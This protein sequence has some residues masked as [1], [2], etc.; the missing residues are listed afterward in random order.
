M[1]LLCGVTLQQMAVVAVVQ[2]SEKLS[3]MLTFLPAIP[4]SFGSVGCIRL[5]MCLRFLRSL[6]RDCWWWATTCTYANARKI[7]KD[8]VPALEFSP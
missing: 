8:A 4:R 6:Q 1:L 5:L 3:Q 2:E 7:P